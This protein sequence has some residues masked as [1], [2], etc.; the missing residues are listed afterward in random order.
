QQAETIEPFSVWTKN[1]FYCVV[2]SKAHQQRRYPGFPFH[3]A[4][5]PKFVTPVN[6][7]YR[8]IS[9]VLANVSCGSL[10]VYRWQSLKD[11]FQG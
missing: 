4:S 7:R 9:G 5:N 8:A 2:T 3:C 1:W 10:A 11:R 6:F